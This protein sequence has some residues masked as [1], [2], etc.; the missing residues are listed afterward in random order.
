METKTLKDYCLSKKGAIEDF[1]FGPDPLVVKVKSKM[2]A[3]IN[4]KS[5]SLKCDPIIAVD[6]RQKYSSVIPGYHLNKQHWNTITLDGSVPDSEL[7]WMVN[8]SYELIVKSL[9]KAQ[10]KS[11]E[12]EC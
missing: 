5:I 7:C 11:L 9:T 6:F 2:F 8:H 3:L 1:P 10:K 12:S 4:E